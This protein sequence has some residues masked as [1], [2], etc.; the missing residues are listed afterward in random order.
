VISEGKDIEDCRQMLQDA[1]YEMI[2]AYRQFKQAG[3][4]PKY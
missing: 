4:K 2:L 1:L 3:L